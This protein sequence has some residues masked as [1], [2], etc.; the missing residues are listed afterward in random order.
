[1]SKKQTGVSYELDSDDDDD[2]VVDGGSGE[3]SED[4]VDVQELQEVWNRFADLMTALKVAPGTDSYFE[5]SA[6]QE[7]ARQWAR[8]LKQTTFDETIIP[9]IHCKMHLQAY[10]YFITV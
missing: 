2:E 10:N 4:H 9:Y 8:N 6:F 1:M 7:R 5:T 3:P